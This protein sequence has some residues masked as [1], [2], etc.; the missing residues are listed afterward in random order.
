MGHL[1]QTT[2]AQ[3]EISVIASGP[4]ANPAAIVQSHN[5]K[6]AL[7]SKHSALVLFINHGCF[8]HDLIFLP[9]FTIRCFD[10]L[11]RRIQR[12]Y[13]D[14]FLKG[15][16]KWASSALASWSVRAVVTIEISIPRTASTC[17]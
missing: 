12:A 11:T 13:P 8:G 16:P 2:T 4:A 1:S 10:R 9:Y 6:F 3:T 14:T 15:I 17:S 7:G 5:R